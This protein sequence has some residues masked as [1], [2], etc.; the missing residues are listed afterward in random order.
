M[1]RVSEVIKELEVLKSQHGDLP[2]VTDNHYEFWPDTNS[3]IITYQK[4]VSFEQG[5]SFDKGF[6]SRVDSI[7]MCCN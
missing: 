7:F 3:L 5:N 1:K 2:V 4:G 6:K